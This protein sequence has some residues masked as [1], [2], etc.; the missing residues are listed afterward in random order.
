MI[1]SR[2]RGSSIINRRHQDSIVLKLLSCRR[3]RH[4]KQKRRA[5]FM[6]PRDHILYDE[7]SYL[8]PILNTIEEEAEHASIRTLSSS[9]Y[10]EDN[11]GRTI[12]GRY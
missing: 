6:M 12:A 10:E 2:L 3:V 11:T 4:R 1:A 5:I 9:I 8:I 7:I